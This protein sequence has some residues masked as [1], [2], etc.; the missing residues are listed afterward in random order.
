[1]AGLRE[2]QKEERQKRILEA[3]RQQFRVAN[4][5]DVTIEVIADEAELSPMTIFNYYGS[6]G[7]I[8]LSLVAESDRH[9]IKKIDN[10]LNT[11][12]V[13]APSAIIA[14]SLT[15]FD[16]AF[17]YLD[18]QTWGHVLA[19][20]IREGDSTFGRGFKRLEDELR[21]LLAV[22]LEKLKNRGLVVTACDCETAATV[23]Y[24]VHNA[25]FI[26]FASDPAVSRDV[27]NNSV[28]QDLR[29]VAEHIAT[30]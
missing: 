16:H 19:T 7:G 6:K 2:R 23:I 12:H 26:E 20:S 5:R 9:L 14:F 17:S 18:Q 10:V 3:A 30:I 13:D 28:T 29:F 4:Y 15:I 8:L 11:N 21:H 25:R 27:I 1:M 24:N 22:L